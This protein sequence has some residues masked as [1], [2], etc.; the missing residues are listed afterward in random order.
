MSA[1]LSRL[2]QRFSPPT[3]DDGSVALQ[4][5]IRSQ[6]PIAAIDQRLGIDESLG[7]G[8]AEHSGGFD[9]PMADSPEPMRVQR[10]AAS[11]TATAPT[12][13]APPPTTK[14]SAANLSIASPAAAAKQPSATA[15]SSTPA[16][17]EDT[18]RPAE[19]APR[20]EPMDP[21]PLFAPFA[22]H[23]DDHH[24]DH[25]GH[26]ATD[27]P[28]VL[29]GKVELRTLEKIIERGETS[30]APS[31]APSDS[32]VRAP[33][34]SAPPSRSE[35]PLLAPP[36]A[37]LA[38]APWVVFDRNTPALPEL[39]HP[40]DA[41]LLEPKPATV[42]PEL[43]VVPL[44]VEPRRPT[45]APFVPEVE[46]VQEVAQTTSSQKSTTGAHAASAPKSAP[47]PQR[48]S[49]PTPTRGKLDIES[50]SQIGPLARHFPNRRRL[51]LRFR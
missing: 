15:L 32:S 2:V 21:G 49:T 43:R 35:A 3:S 37:R 30:L 17:V 46:P 25:H 40:F 9:E 18:P 22:L 5:F 50:I 38:N 31:L 1:Y 41:P 47:T 24:D 14:A 29:P 11:A 10:K 34:I 12:L 26:R 48:P 19:L 51:R 27:E 39:P 20:R 44:L 8:L 36:P 13:A 7:H 16:R 33:R 42:R 6:S 4:P 23:H 45:P 28:G